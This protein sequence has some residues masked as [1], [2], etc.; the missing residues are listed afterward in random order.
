VEGSA[1]NDSTAVRW[2]IKWKLITIITVLMVSLV[3]ALSYLQISLQKRILEDEL[4]NRIELMKANLIERGKSFIINLSQQVENDIASFNFSGVVE[5][6]KDSVENNRAIKYA[7]LT[8][9]FGKAFIHTL[10]PEL[11]QTELT[12]ARDRKA[13]SQKNIAAITYK[14]NAESG[15]IHISV[16][17]LYV[18]AVSC[19]LNTGD[20][21]TDCSPAGPA[22]HKNHF[23]KLL[24]LC[25]SRP[26]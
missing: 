11:A 17:S 9:S 15:A 3:V 2:S 19:S 26:P 16:C 18:F 5:A 10:K 1:L 24:I 21:W 25:T 20:V 14:E 7:I 6:V 12:E 23:L 22:S 4:N 8:D 13:L